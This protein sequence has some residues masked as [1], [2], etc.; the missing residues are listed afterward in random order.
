MSSRV[1]VGSMRIP[2]ITPHRA[3][4][5]PLHLSTRLQRAG[6]GVS[7]RSKSRVVVAHKCKGK[8]DVTGL[9]GIPD[10]VIVVAGFTVVLV[11]VIWVGIVKLRVAG[12]VNVPEVLGDLL[13]PVG[14]RRQNNKLVTG[15]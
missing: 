10:R 3:H 14:C 5:I 15:W 6:E 2:H 12:V 9:G 11:I 13:G 7:M 1:A 4:F 8:Q